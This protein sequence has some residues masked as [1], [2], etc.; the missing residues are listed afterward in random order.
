VFFFHSCAQQKFE[1]PPK[2]GKGKSDK[3]KIALPNK[4]GYVV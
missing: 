1:K 2:P 4:K 3:L